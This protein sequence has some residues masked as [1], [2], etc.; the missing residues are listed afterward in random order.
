[1][2]LY[3][4]DLVGRGLITMA[5]FRDAEE[6]RCLSRV[7]TGGRSGVTLDPTIVASGWSQLYRGPGILKGYVGFKGQGRVMMGLV[8]SELG[9][10]LM[11]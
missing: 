9:Y 11:I 1:M 5:A 6:P 4:F 7:R 10:A 3:W 8:V 2:S